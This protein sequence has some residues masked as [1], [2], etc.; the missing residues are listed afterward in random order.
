[1]GK[2]YHYFTTY[3]CNIPQHLL[4]VCDNCGHVE[5]SYNSC[6]NIN[7]PK[8]Q[9]S[10]QEEWVEAQLERLLPVGY[11]HLVFTLPHELNAIIY[12]NHS[13]L[14]SMLMKAAGDT[15][16]ELAHN[17][18]HLGALPD[19][20]AVLHTWGQNLHYHPH[21]HCIVSAGGL[22]NDRLRFIYSGKKFF[23]PV[24]VLPRKF[25]GKFLYHL[26]EVWH[27]GL[28]SFYGKAL[29]LVDGD[30]F[31]DFL[32][33]LYGKDW[34]VYCKKPFKAPIHVVRYLGRYTHR[35]A[36]RFL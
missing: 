14:Y 28:L 8:C 34:V 31:K 6:L 21:V 22:S 32:D 2:T 12:Q 33:R 10:R 36:A 11:F 17:P 29:E 20:T 30:N 35:V 15:I 27:D 13:L 16:L 5:I 24:K 26:K 23:M 9:G 4:I 7:C 1:M 25:R 3:S 19:V 18:K